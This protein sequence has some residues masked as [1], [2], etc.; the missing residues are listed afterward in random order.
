MCNLRSPLKLNLLWVYPLP[1]D[2]LGVTAAP[3]ER[4]VSLQGHSQEFKVQCRLLVHFYR[5]VKPAEDWIKDFTHSDKHSTTKVHLSPIFPISLPSGN[6]KVWTISCSICQQSATSK[7]SK[8]SLCL[9]ESGSFYVDYTNDVFSKI[10]QWR[11]HISYY[12]VRQITLWSWRRICK[13]QTVI[14]TMW[15]MGNNGW[16]DNS[17]VKSMR[18]LQGSTCS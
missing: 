14:P 10:G 13:R 11:S 5:P 2:W 16:V 9:R 15:L 18:W 6:L 8:Y 4:E 1:S 17:S 7:E 3:E 12:D